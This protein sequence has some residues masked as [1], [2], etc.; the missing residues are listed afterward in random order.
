M[1]NMKVLKFGGTSVGDAESIQAVLEIVKKA[2][3]GGERPVVVLSAMGGVTNLLTK[4]AENAAERI[5]FAE[6]LERLEA[7]HFGVVKKLMAVRH[8]N[9]VITRLKLLLNELDDILQGVSVL[10]LVHAFERASGRTIPYRVVER[11]AGDVAAVYA[12]PALAQD[13]LGWRAQLEVEAMCRD[14]WRW[15]SQNPDGFAA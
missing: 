2:H 11:R 6:D 4:M 13:L 15:Q 12:D 3:E 5:P 7:R 1:D 8:Q 10:Q 14:A 9:P